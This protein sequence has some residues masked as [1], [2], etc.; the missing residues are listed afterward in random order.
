MDGN[1]SL[2]EMSEK[3]GGRFHLVSLTQHRIREIK[4]GAPVLTDVEHELLIDTVC[5][6]IMEDCVSYE[7]VSLADE[8][9]IE[10]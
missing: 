7:E 6:E 1:F 2:D 9:E 3:V 5:K 4:S 10:E 8:S